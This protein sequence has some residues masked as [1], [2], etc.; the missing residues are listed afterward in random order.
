MIYTYTHTH[1]HAY[2]HIHT[3][4]HIYSVYSFYVNSSVYGNSS[5]NSTVLHVSFPEYYHYVNT[6]PYHVYIPCFYCMIQNPICYTYDLR[7]NIF[8][9]NLQ[10]SET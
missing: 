5:V 9:L 7:P 3:H 8:F 6:I 1:I 10:Q 2:I 4:T